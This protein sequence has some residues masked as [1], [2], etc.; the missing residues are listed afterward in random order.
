MLKVALDLAREGFAVFPVIDKRPPE[1][2]TGGFRNATR[3]EQTIRMWWARWPHARVAIWPGACEPR[4]VG[5]DI[6]IKNGAPGLESALDLAEMLP[7]TLEAK[8][9]SGGQHLL[10]RAPKDAPPIG[11][12][13][14]APGID[15]RADEG[16]LVVHQG[17]F[18][19]HALADAPPL[20]LQ[21]LTAAPQKPASEREPVTPL[22]TPAQL[23][24]ARE[25]AAVLLQE[26]PKERY[27]KACRIK[28]EGVSAEQC[29]TIMREIGFPEEGQTSLA[30]KVASA[31]HYG[32]RAPG[33]KVVEL[34]EFVAKARAQMVGPLP[35]PVLT[36]DEVT[37]EQGL[38]AVIKRWIYRGT[39]TIY[40]GP[41]SRFKSFLTLDQAAH[42][43]LG[44]DWAGNK[45]TEAQDVL[46]IV[47]EGKAGIGNRVKAWEQHHGV[48]PERLR[49][50]TVPFHLVNDAAAL[51]TTL[52]KLAE[53]GF[54]PSVIYI[55]TLASAT[56]G[57]N[58]NTSEMGLPIG[59]CR[60]IAADRG[61]ALVLVDH[62]GKDDEDGTRG[63]RG[64]SGKEG[65]ADAVFLITGDRD[66]LTASVTVRKPPKDGRRPDGLTF[67]GIE[68]VLGTDPEGDQITSLVFD[69][70]AG[71]VPPPPAERGRRRPGK[72]DP[73][74]TMLYRTAF[75]E[76]VHDVPATT[77]AVA[78]EMAAHIPVRAE[79]DTPGYRVVLQGQVK[80]WL[81][82]IVK[83]KNTLVPDVKACECL[84]PDGKTRGW[85]RT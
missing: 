28:D 71:V 15:V 62:T 80:S 39:L 20:L 70:D 63:A 40:V 55:D 78:Q 30:E 52:D 41:Y 3:D 68:L 59:V 22:D 61:V 4:M 31:Y 24:R 65:A 5:I 48:K 26:G 32:Q 72:A 49:F 16:Y 75:L 37:A 45:V 34:R 8:T 84:M 66:A 36:I 64:W 83:G 76:V 38:V 9:P 82:N 42:I 58:E 46:Y 74:I 53:T 14:L 6:D 51:C 29:Y 2:F 54:S 33:S 1:G 81:D 56:E 77:R 21:R 10:Y 12:H 17:K 13:K 44:R 69:Y 43:A 27:R 19:G 85:R 79:D 57:V 67:K 23:A 11:N 50:I 60:R 73:T 47:A 25:V 35:L 18:N 7:P